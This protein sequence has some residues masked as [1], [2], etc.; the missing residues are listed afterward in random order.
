VLSHVS[1]LL[2]EVI[3]HL[4]TL[5]LFGTFATFGSFHFGLFSGESCQQKCYHVSVGVIT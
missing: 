4:F 5:A 2:A 1:R 3:T